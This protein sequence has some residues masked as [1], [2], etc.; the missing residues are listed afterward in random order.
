MI[1][2]NK[3]YVYLVSSLLRKMSTKNKALMVPR[4]SK[5]PVS[6]RGANKDSNKCCES[7]S[8]PTF[9]IGTTVT[10][11]EEIFRGAKYDILRE[12]ERSV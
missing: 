7:E 11:A 3:L 6:L 5:G 4:C 2:C 12:M 8:L 10:Y 1:Y 9:R